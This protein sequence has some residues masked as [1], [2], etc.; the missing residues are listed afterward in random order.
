MNGIWAG[1]GG[2][3]AWR[4]SFT[5]MPGL[6]NGSRCGY[7][8]PSSRAR[9]TPLFQMT[10]MKPCRWLLVLPLTLARS[11]ALQSGSGDAS[12]LFVVNAVEATLTGDTLVFAGGSPQ[13]IAFTDRPARKFGSI[14]MA[15]LAKAWAE[16]SDSFASDPPNAIFN[17]TYT[18][19]GGIKSQCSIEVELMAAPSSGSPSGWTWKVVEAARWDGCPEPGTP[20]KIAPA[21][22]F[23][24]PDTPLL[25][26]DIL[27]IVLTIV[28]PTAQ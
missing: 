2:A 17:G 19:E 13:V 16:G 1:G 20:L 5:T 4:L 28:N 11:C 15:D 10:L 3:V 8:S 21:S 26:G 6:A 24:D 18:N 22:F 7:F 27:H 9:K 23:I 12:W 14:S 25:P